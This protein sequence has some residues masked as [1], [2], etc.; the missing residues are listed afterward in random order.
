MLERRVNEFA[1]VQGRPC[2]LC[3][4]DAPGQVSASRLLV[5]HL[6]NSL[7]VLKGT[8]L[9][10]NLGRW[11]WA[12]CLR[13]NLGWVWSKPQSQQSV[14]CEP[15]D[16]ASQVQT[17]IKRHRWHPKLLKTYDA[18]LLSVGWRRFQF[19]DEKMKSVSLWES[20][21]VKNSTGH[22][23]PLCYVRAYF[24]SFSQLLLAKAAIQI[25]P[26]LWWIW[27]NK[28]GRIFFWPQ[29]SCQSLPFQ[30]R[31]KTVIVIV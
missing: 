13:V 10:F 9:N 17:R 31:R 21:C 18:L 15:T 12:V 29:K 27:S 24:C 5:G 4:R 1:V 7:D 19:L 11:F 16:F 6:C 22:V 30:L 28:A 2:G 3:C 23:K 25:T 8:M 20:V 14:F 26:V